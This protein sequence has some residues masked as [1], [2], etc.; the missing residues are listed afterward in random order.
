M[1]LKHGGI[2]LF[3]CASDG[4]PEHGTS[5]TDG[6]ASPFT[7]DYYMNLN[8]VIVKTN[9]PLD[10]MFSKYEINTNHNSCD[11]YFWGIK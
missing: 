6:W 1:H 7:N 8:E 9:L 5:R 2:Y 11:L 10:K 4:R 3:T